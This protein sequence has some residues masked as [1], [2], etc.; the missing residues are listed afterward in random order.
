MAKAFVVA[1]DDGLESR[2][3]FENI[4]G[5]TDVAL[6]DLRDYFKTF[7]SDI[8]QLQDFVGPNLRTYL[9]SLNSNYY[10][11]VKDLNKYVWTYGVTNMVRRKSV[12]GKLQRSNG[13]KAL[14]NAYTI[15][16]KRWMSKQL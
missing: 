5:V 2:Q 15:A 9:S 6:V 13:F 3:D 14:S 12:L 8:K 7:N 1:M 16:R 10:D 4:F 11:K